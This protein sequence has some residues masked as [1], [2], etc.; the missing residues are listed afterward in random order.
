M[1]GPND[2]YDPKQVA[3][4]TPETL[5]Q[6]VEDAEKAF[7]Q[8]ADLEELAAVKPAHLGD[9]SPLLTARREIGAL[10]PK[11]RAEAAGLGSVQPQGAWGSGKLVVR[12]PPRLPIRRGGE[13]Q[14][15]GEGAGVQV[16]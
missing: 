12:H 15:E 3:A 6:A 16:R 2:A 14:P 4:L 5:A 8:A 9:R 11:A 1:S 7:A 10:P 13:A